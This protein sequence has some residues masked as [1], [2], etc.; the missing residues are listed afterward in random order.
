[1]LCILKI[2][3]FT[4]RADRPG[5]E[6]LDAYSA[7]GKY[8]APVFRVK[9]EAGNA[10]ALKD[11]NGK[12]C[13]IYPQVDE[14]TSRFV[15]RIKAF[16]APAVKNPNLPRVMFLLTRGKETGYGAYRQARPDAKRVLHHLR[17]TSATGNHWE[18]FWIVL[19]WEPVPVAYRSNLGN[20]AELEAGDTD[21][22]IRAQLP[23]AW[24][25]PG[26]DESDKLVI[27]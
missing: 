26:T 14:Q 13:A 27:D 2:A 23:T 11:C 1:M 21:P 10:V 9:D 22:E 8:T 19:G 15:I 24:V 20:S 17:W 12:V 5:H 4:T 18:D 16:A 6:V 25:S 7:G 3:G